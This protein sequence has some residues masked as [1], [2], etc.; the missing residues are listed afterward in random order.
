[1]GVI[2]PGRHMHVCMYEGLIHIY[3]SGAEIQGGRGCPGT[4][5]FLLRELGTP[6]INAPCVKLNACSGKWVSILL[7]GFAES[8]AFSY[9]TGEARSGLRRCGCAWF[10]LFLWHPQSL[11]LIFASVYIYNIYIY[12]IMLKYIQYKRSII[13]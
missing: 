2:C 9:A 10:I 1:M 11:V 5:K 13:S 8:H 4:P 3:I 6:Q 7:S 12:I